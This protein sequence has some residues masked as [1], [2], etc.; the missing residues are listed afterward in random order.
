MQT[1]VT[2][3][4][5]STM[6]IVIRVSFHWIM[7]ATMKVVTKVD[8]T[9]MVSVSFSDIPLLTLLPLVVAWTVTGAA[10]FGPKYAMFCCKMCLMNS[11]R[12]AL[13]VQIAAM[14]MSRLTCQWLRS[15]MKRLTYRVNV[16][17]GKFGDERVN[18]IETAHVVRRAS[19]SVQVCLRVFVHL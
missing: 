10:A 11:M 4:M 18:K 17:Q 13:V 3:K 5:V 2:I 1:P 6:L 8:T 14:E 7:K 15:C 9:C 16:Y 12:K 19:A